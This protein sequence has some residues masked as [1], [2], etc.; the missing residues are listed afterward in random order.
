MGRGGSSAGRGGGG[1]G[2]QVFGVAGAGNTLAGFRDGGV[3]PRDWDGATQRR[4]VDYLARNR[5]L[6]QLRFGQDVIAGQLDRA[7]AANNDGAIRNLQAMQ[8]IHT[9]AVDRRAF[10]LKLE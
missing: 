6:R 2:G 9:A 3:P 10:V 1:T 7:V 4:A 8:R 5:N